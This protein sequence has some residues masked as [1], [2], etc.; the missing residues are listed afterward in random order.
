MFDPPTT[1]T[2][3]AVLE[4]IDAQLA[5]LPTEDPIR[6]QLEHHRRRAALYLD[7]AGR[8]YDDLIPGRLH[9]ELVTT[10]PEATTVQ[11]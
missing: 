6:D 3:T 5:D 2:L 11:G 10:Y 4:H 1:R 9:S 7:A 8:G